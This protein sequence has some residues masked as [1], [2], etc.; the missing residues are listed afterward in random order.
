[1]RIEFDHWAFDGRTGLEYP[2]IALAVIGF[3][4]GMTFRLKVLLVI[5]IPLVPATIIFA[6]GNGFGFLGTAL[7]IMIA[8]SVVQGSFFVGLVVRASLPNKQRHVLFL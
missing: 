4:V 6:L 1:V 5:L 3:A 7:M 8:Q 2:G